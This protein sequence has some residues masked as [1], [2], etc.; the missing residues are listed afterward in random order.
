MTD[1]P[2]L[3]SGTE[4]AEILGVSVDRIGPMVDEGLL[5][6]HADDGGEPQFLRSELEAV[7]HLGG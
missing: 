7:R 2:E 4:A 3:V 6:A 5:T 1:T